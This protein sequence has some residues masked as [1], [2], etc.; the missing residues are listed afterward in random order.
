MPTRTRKPSANFEVAHGRSHFHSL[1]AANPAVFVPVRKLDRDAKYVLVR[2]GRPGEA[3]WVAAIDPAQDE[4]MTWAANP[5]GESTAPTGSASDRS[6]G[7]VEWVWRPSAYSKS[8]LYPIL[9]IT[10]ETGELFVDLAG[11]VYDTLP[12]AHA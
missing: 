7:E 11:A 4:F 12:D 6:G 8:P 10:T 9:R 5:S 1:L 2:L 3:G